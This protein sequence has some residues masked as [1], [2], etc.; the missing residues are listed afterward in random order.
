MNSK[1][2]LAVSGCILLATTA[3]AAGTADDDSLL[4]EVVIS[5]TRGPEG[6]TRG[7]LGSS[8]SVVDSDDME[9]RQVRIVSDVLRDIP[10]VAVSRSGAVGGLTQVRIRGTEGNHTLVLIDGVEASDPYYGEFDFGTLIA[11]DVAR[12]EVLRG[13]QSALY[14]SDAIGGVI[15]Y[16]TL[17]G[18]EAPGL[19]SRLEY[20]SFNTVDAAARFGG[21]SGILDYSVSGGVQ[22]T[23]GYATARDGER[24]VGARNI[25]L[26]GRF[27]WTLSDALRIKTVLRLNN[28]R[29]EYNDQD[30]DSP[31]ATGTYGFVIDSDDYYKN[32]SLLG[33]VR[34]E[35]G[36]PGSR[37]QQGFS[38]QG[39]DAK[40]NGFSGGARDS[41]D[42][43]GRVKASYDSTF[44]FGTD[45]VA[46]VL[47]LGADYE[48]ESFQNT[49]PIGPYPGISAEQA[50]KHSI[51]NIGL[52]AQ[53]NLMANDRL[54]FGASLRGDNN[55]RFD[56]ALT[57][58]VQGSYLFDSGT[59]LRAATG[60][61]IKNPSATEI[62]GYDPGSYVGNP[63]LKPEK[64]EGW[65]IGVDQQ[66]MEGKVLLGATYFDSEL[67]NEIATDCSD[68]PICT[69]YNEPTL[70]KQKGVELTVEA[71][72]AQWRIA[73]AYTD[74]NAKQN[75][76]KEV[77]RPDTIASLN[78]GWRAESETYGA[79]LT[80]RYNGSMLDSNFT[81]RGSPRVTLGSY[82]LVNLGLDWKLS[83]KTQVY[84]RIENLLDEDY[85]EV[86][87]Y[88]TPG[89]AVYA[90]VRMKF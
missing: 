28:T 82:T 66:L 65:E 42:K 86:Y 16:S 23:D 18:R 77:R 68:Y 26:N 36:S 78:L 81:G 53:Y 3:Q 27:D 67:E 8:V 71:R 57:Y 52:V 6:I 69:P 85:E 79:N 90:G 5:A 14:G 2:G 12:V 51:D 72:V 61:G 35:L 40:R 7:M 63:D 54:G 13:Q 19:R 45:T 64:S 87:T 33:M 31:Y 20:G 22:D 58:R 46:Q 10:G 41:G 70:S 59:R 73:A 32:R 34:A 21:E 15:S 30:F 74:L 25:A 83:D 1:V 88:A 24:D 37:W 4:E 76:V 39:V 11:D 50:E 38:L 47:T 75:A 89:R 49:A 29:A 80:V 17:T 43:G 56:D 9:A 48:D 84:G 44:R 55:K 60:S 62:F